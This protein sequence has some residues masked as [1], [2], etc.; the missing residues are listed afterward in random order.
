MLEIGL[1]VTHTIFSGIGYENKYTTTKEIEDLL[2]YDGVVL[3]IVDRP[4]FWFVR[5]RSVAG[6]SSRRMLREDFCVF[7]SPGGAVLIL[8]TLPCQIFS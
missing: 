8:Q 4:I 7:S 5:C 1:F 6:E 2:T 3:I